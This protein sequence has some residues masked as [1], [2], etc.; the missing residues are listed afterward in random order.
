MAAGKEQV[1]AR[2][3]SGRISFFIANTPAV[4]YS[5]PNPVV[6]TQKRK[7]KMCEAFTWIRSFLLT[8]GAMCPYHKSQCRLIFENIGKRLVSLS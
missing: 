1:K 8:T 5:K 6:K 7:E 3:I 4:S 2:I